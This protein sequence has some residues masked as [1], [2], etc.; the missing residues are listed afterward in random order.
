MTDGVKWLMDDGVAKLTLNAPARHNLLDAA[1]GARIAVLLEEAKRDTAVKALLIAAEGE[2]FCA[3]AETP[4]PWHEALSGFEKPVIVAVDGEAAGA[5]FTLAL[6]C[7]FILATPRTFFRVPPNPADASMLWLLPRSLGLQR[8]KELV[9]SGRRMEA[10]EAESLGMVAEIVPAPALATRAL[11][12]ARRF[13]NAPTE[14]LAITKASLT[15]SLHLDQKALAGIEALAQAVAATSPYHRQ[16]V[17][18][19]LAKQPLEFDWDRMERE[20]PRP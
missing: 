20:D 6:A 2:T 5:G 12:F 4:Q 18:R 14:A 7:D 15:Q 10:A 13:R 11:A 19:F 9:L 17:E 16:A 3:G 8:A 1:M